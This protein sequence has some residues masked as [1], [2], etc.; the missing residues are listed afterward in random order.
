MAEF[1]FKELVARAHF[2]YV[3]PA[4][5]HWWKNNKTLMV[6]PSLKNVFGS[7]LLGKKYFFTLTL[8]SDTESFSFPNEPLISISLVKTIVETATVGKYR[9]GT[10][11]EYINTEDY[12]LTIRGVCVNTEDDEAY[13]T[14]QVNELNKMFAVN[15]ALEVVSNPFLELFKIRKLVLKEISLDEMM[16]QPNLQ[17][18]R[19]TAVSD[20][21]F[22]ADLANREDTRS[23]FLNA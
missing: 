22:Y 5:P 17:K 10:V 1:N 23:N 14:D 9:K 2:D 19:I 15:E 16:G 12:Q 18:Y 7:N 8:K 21:D 6:L 20:E 13:P 11:K 3:G 4:F